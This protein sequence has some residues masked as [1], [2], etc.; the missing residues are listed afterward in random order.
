MK[1]IREYKR[2]LISLLLLL[3]VVLPGSLLFGTETEAVPATQHVEKGEVIR[4]GYIDYKGF[5]EKDEKGNFF[6][7]G[8]EY[9][10]TIS[11]YT[12]WEYE[13]VY[14][15][16]DEHLENLKN[17]TIDF[18]CQ[19]QKTD[20]RENEFIFS[21]YS[22]GNESNLLYARQDDTR[23]FYED[24]YAMDKMTI[25]F[26]E[27]SYQNDEFAKYAELKD[28][29]YKS[30]T[31][32]NATA[33]FEALENEE[34]DGVVM[35]SVAKVTNCKVLCRFGS[36]PYYMMTS[37]M[38]GELMDEL[39]KAQ[40]NL[41]YFMEDNQDFQNQLYDKYYGDSAAQTDL[42]FTRTEMDF[43]RKADTI[44]VGQLIS[45]YPISYL[46][47]H[48]VLQGINED[49]LEKI[50]SM[51]G[52]KLVSAPL[53]KG[54]SPAEAITSGEYD[55]VMG[56]M[57][58][59]I[60]RQDPEL[61]L[62]TSYMEGT[63]AMVVPTL[64]DFDLKEPHTIGIK[65]S[66]GYFGKYLSANYP[67]FEIVF[68]D[69]NEE[70]LSDLVDEKI[71]IMAE[72]IYVIEY[73]LQKPK[74]DSLKIV[75]TTYVEE[76]S[77]FV[78]REGK[79]QPIISIL[80]RCIQYISDDEINEII[81]ENTSAK[82]YVLTLGDVI[83]K[84]RM[85]II[86]IAIFAIVCFAFLFYNSIAKQKHV[87]EMDAKNTI[88]AEAVLKAEDANEAK[89]QF[90]SNMSHEIRTPMNAIV[91]ITDIAKK[92][93]DNPEKIGDYLEKIEASSTVLLKIINDVL[94]MSAIESGKVKIESAPFNM[95]KILKNIY[96]VYQPQCNN[97]G[98]ELVMETDYSHKHL[99]GDQLR[100]SQ[101]LLNLISNAYKFT[102]KGGRITISVVEKQVVEDV[103]FMEFIIKDT[104]CGM[105]EEMLARLY[106][107]FEQES[108][109][110]AQKYGG[111]GLGTSIAKGLVEMMAGAIEA[112]SVPGEGTTF[113]VDIPFEIDEAHKMAD[114]LDEDEI[115]ESK[116]INTAN[117]DFTGYK[118]L[119]V[120]DN[121][122]NAEIALELFNLVNLEAD[123][124]FDGADGVKLFEESTPGTY[125]IILMDLQMPVMNG[126]DAARVIRKSS[127]PQSE[128]IPIF[129]MTANA[130]R[131]DVSASLIA[132]M[133][134]HLA[135]PIDT[136]LLYD[137][138]KE[139]LLG[140]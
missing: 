80:N 31:Y 130:F 58:N 3:T 108:A 35:G 12:G 128:S 87:E 64:E 1:K 113:C 127:H 48:K 111:S 97:K 139:V 98:I 73:L 69:D 29:E 132:G 140:E 112:Q 20:E 88:L 17:G 123:R 105:S 38:N 120:E 28:F 75:S 30:K 122:L 103:T 68:Y 61:H 36:T 23:F 47:D 18:L 10:E 90:L 54:Q 126:L 44:R 72:N 77:C 85:P 62:S 32:E 104:G 81:L 96:E 49:I 107:P 109:G 114:T 67:Q 116:G 94:D 66:Y 24:F 22:V 6:G 136:K 37:N 129:A 91:G 79:C 50:S 93:K 15:S 11:K 117:Y 118:V 46:D 8:V 100:L 63:F 21:Q 124:A 55:L 110:V 40:S 86:T 65:R 125:D 119:L 5:I 92:H 51:T 13:Y 2:R 134:G 7:Y 133:N 89:S 82:P 57:D 42:L 27:N 14:G 99:I 33:C 26:M 56:I 102:E 34:I 101:V 137:T 70:I 19:A 121:D 115:E 106:Q 83:Y 53:K 9:L 43:I 138:L 41:G 45:R 4:I 39:N 60:Y 16:W 135:K 74:Y 76:K 95:K 71:D 59:E 84:Y 78:A 131:E 52:L 25:G